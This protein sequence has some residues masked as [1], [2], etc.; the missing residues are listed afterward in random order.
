MLVCVCLCACVCV[1]VR[2]GECWLTLRCLG[3]TSAQLNIC[4]QANRALCCELAVLVVLVVL[5]VSC[6]SFY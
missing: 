1:C 6:L 3:Q 5:V 4:L 2:V